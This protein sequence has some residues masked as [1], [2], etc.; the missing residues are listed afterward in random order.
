[1]KFAKLR[2]KLNHNPNIAFEKGNDLTRQNGYNSNLWESCSQV[3]MKMDR[4]FTFDPHIV[5][6]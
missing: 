6:Q 1:M 2:V 4:V 5:R 3:P